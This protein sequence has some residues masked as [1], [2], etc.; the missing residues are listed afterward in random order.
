MANA[1]GPCIGQWDRKA[2][3]PNRPN[4]I[5]TS[6]NRN[7]A[8]RTDGNPNTHTFVA[9]PEVVMAL[10]IAG[11][12]TFNP[13]TDTLINQDGKAV[14]LD[15]PEGIELPPMG[16]SVKDAG[17]IPPDKEAAKSEVAIAPHSK[18]LQKLTPFAP[19]RIEDFAKMPLL[20]Q[21][22]GKCTTDHI[23]MAGPWLKYR[24]HLENISDNLLMGAINRFSNQANSVKNQLTGKYEEVSTVAKQ[25]KMAGISSIVVAEE[26]YGEG[27]S[28]EHAALEPR[29]LEVKAILAKSFARIHETNLK[30]QG[31]LAL[32]FDNPQDYE[33]IQEDDRIS[34]NG[35][36][37]LAPGKPVEVVLHHAGGSEETILACHTYNEQQI[38]WFRAGSALNCQA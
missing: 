34:V 15:E 17:Y 25:Y 38:K 5:I 7:F 26:N 10:T 35:I 18:R 33:R 31:M 28:R 22:K 1:C 27:S 20:I 8:K 4:S 13:L 23:S 24:G 6:F 29:F 19:L 3:D 16:F 11:D 37:A 9:S 14:K 12:L 2:D 32:T 21:T 36:D 30:K